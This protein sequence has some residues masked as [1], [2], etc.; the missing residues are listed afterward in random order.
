M[1]KLS[2]LAAAAILPA[3][4]ACGVQQVDA[5]PPTVTYAYQSE[6]DLDRIRDEAD[7]HCA[8]E[9]GRRGVLIDHDRTANGYEV[10]FACE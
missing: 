9:Y 3:L 4:V 10:T 2:M 8:E 5:T 6:Y 7:R 1:R